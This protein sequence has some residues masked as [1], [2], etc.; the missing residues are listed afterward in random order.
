MSA[1]SLSSQTVP[2][3]ARSIKRRRRTEAQVQQLDAQI[4]T[5]LDQDRPQSVRHVSYRMTE[6][7]LPEPVEKTDKGYDQVQDRITKLRR[8]GVLPYG[9]ITDATRRGYFTDTFSGADDF[10]RWV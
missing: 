10:V 9:W 7:R 4:L 2:Y 5:G 3:Q 8:S 6:P 1:A